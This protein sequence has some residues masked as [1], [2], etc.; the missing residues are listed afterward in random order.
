MTGNIDIVD[1]QTG[2]VIKT[3]MLNNTRIEEKQ[4]KEKRPDEVDKDALLNR[5]LNQNVVGF[6]LV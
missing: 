6:M 4:E 2:Q 3:K 5:C 1:I